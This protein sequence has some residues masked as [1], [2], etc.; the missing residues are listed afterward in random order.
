MCRRWLRGQG[1]DLV[2]VHRLQQTHAD[3]PGYR[4][5]DRVELGD[6][7]GELIRGLLQ[8]VLGAVAIGALGRRPAADAHAAFGSGALCGLGLQHGAELRMGRALGVAADLD[9]VLQHRLA[10][11][12]RPGHAA[13]DAAAFG[14]AGPEFA[15]DFRK[16]RIF[17]RLGMDA[18]AEIGVGQSPAQHERL[19]VDRRRVECHL[20][21]PRLRF[22]R[23]LLGTRWC[24]RRARPFPAAGT[25]QLVP[26]FF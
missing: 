9:Q 1:G 20:I 22:V 24:G 2:F 17:R 16:D 4:Q 8:G 19:R 23:I 12:G 11:G 6:D 15:L 7:A 18:G 13:G 10:H 5:A 25:N 14:K 26:R 21:E 3:G